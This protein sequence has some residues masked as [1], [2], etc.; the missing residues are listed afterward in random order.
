MRGGTPAVA[1][2]VIGHRGAVVDG[3][4]GVLVPTAADLGPAIA[5]LAG[6]ADRRAALATAAQQRA[7]TFTWDRTAADTLEVLLG[8]AR[9]TVRR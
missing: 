6:D 1:T 2:D 5:S 7:A 4:T 8:D 3:R 9:R